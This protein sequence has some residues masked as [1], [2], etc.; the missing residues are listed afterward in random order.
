[1][2]LAVALTLFSSVLSFPSHAQYTG[3]SESG[4]TTQAEALTSEPIRN[5]V[6]EAYYARLPAWICP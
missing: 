4:Q 2:C 1:M 6:G 5:F 3:P